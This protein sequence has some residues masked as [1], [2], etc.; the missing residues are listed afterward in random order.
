MLNAISLVQDLNSSR[1]VHFSTTITTIPRAPIIYFSDCAKS[2]QLQLVWPSL[3][4]ST[5]FVFQRLESYTYLFFFSLSFNFTLWLAG[6]QFD[7]LL[8]LLLLLLLL[9]HIPIPPLLYSSSDVM[10]IV[11][12]NGH[13]DTS[14]NPGRDWLHFT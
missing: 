11:V 13:G 9:F 1:R 4:C 3:S 10:V 14:S 6:T 2:T 7:K 12:G 8:L 5:V